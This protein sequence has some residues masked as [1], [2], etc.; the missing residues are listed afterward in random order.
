MNICPG[1]FLR[2]KVRVILRTRCGCERQIELGS[3]LPK[4]YYIPLPHNAG[5]AFFMGYETEYSMPPSNYE[6]RQFDL[7]S[8]RGEVALYKEV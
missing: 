3:P 8:I 6:M 7:E 1:P 5:R 4:S 2:P